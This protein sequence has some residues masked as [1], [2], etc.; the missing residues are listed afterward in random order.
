MSRIT[1]PISLYFDTD[2][3]SE[4]SA[5]FS[6]DDVHMP[7]YVYV[8][9]PLVTAFYVPRDVLVAGLNRS[10]PPEA[11]SCKELCLQDAGFGWLQA[12]LPLPWA[13]P[14]RILILRQ[15]LEEFLAQAFT[16]VPQGQ[17]FPDYDWD[18]ALWRL[19]DPDH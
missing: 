11:C 14:L 15:D 5:F 1:M 13:D 19:L 12:V 8:Y 6:Y 16:L 7:F 2:G 10:C 17:E 3:E 4:L 9:I 18:E